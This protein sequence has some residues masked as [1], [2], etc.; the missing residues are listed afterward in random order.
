MEKV[1]KALELANGRTVGSQ[2]RWIKNDQV[3]RRLGEIV[4]PYET[5]VK[6]A[7]D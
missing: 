3:S 5:K 6:K 4:R 1:Q 2:E 7:R